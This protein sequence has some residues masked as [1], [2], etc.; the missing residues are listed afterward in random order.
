MKNLSLLCLLIATGLTVS[1]N[2]VAKHHHH[3]HHHNVPPMMRDYGPLP[4]M[5]HDQGI[6]TVL[7]K[8]DTN[9]DNALSKDELD[10]YKKE[11]LEYT[12]Q[13]TETTISFE[14]ADLNQ[15]GFVSFDEYML[16]PKVD[17]FKI[18]GF[19]G[20][21]HKH[22]H[23][24]K[25]NTAENNDK[26]ANHDSKMEEK[27]IQDRKMFHSFGRFS[28]FDTDYDGKLSFDEYS[29][30]IS[31]RKENIQA[32]QDTLSKIDFNSIDL[33]NDGLISPMEIHHYIG[34]LILAKAPKYEK[35]K[36]HDDE[37]YEDEQSE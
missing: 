23:D 24:H 3:S 22:K 26:I 5:G 37:F 21:G 33:N 28:F 9:Q 34:S 15:D 20:P 16:L 2:A 31:V 18:M 4:P 35:M 13:L 27:R 11:G 10:N 14:K 30:L 29:T 19:G 36:S 17:K 8:F 32:M 6:T 7:Y 1:G 12:K 25:H